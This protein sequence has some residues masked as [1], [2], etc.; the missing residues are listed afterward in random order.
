MAGL[1]GVLGLW[2]LKQGRW[3]ILLLAVIC[4]FD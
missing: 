4:F 3:A 2:A 1:F